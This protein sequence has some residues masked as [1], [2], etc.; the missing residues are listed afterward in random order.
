[1][2]LNICFL[3]PHNKG[4]VLLNI[5]VAVLL[6]EFINT[7]RACVCVCVHARVRSCMYTSGWQKKCPWENSFARRHNWATKTTKSANRSCT[8]CCHK[9]ACVRK[10]PCILV[11]S[12]FTHSHQIAC[13]WKPYSQAFIFIY[14][15]PIHGPWYAVLLVSILQVFDGIYGRRTI[16]RTMRALSTVGMQSACQLSFIWLSSFRST[17][18]RDCF[19]HGDSF[20]HALVRVG[21]WCSVYMYRSLI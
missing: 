11:L 14:A 7:V 12:P 9:I 15:S 20:C 17:L 3:F 2:Q 13:I 5:V 21:A 8:T 10:P 4:V 18:A 1:M 16:R 19:C 6:D